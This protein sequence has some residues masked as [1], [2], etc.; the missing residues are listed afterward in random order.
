MTHKQKI[1]WGTIGLIA[2]A[3]VLIIALPDLL[4]GGL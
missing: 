4:G 1:A 2:W 3:V